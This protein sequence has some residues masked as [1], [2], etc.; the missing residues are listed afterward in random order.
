MS[1][2]NAEQIDSLLEAAGVDNTREILNAF[3][4]STEGLIAELQ[5]NVLDTDLE[6]ASLTAH[7]LKGAAANVGASMIVEGARMIETACRNGDDVSSDMLD[8]L[9]SEFMEA[10]QVFE[11]YLARFAATA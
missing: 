10:R 11:E 2:I 9:T 7:A 8:M 1:Q 6:N 3:W 4:Q 5:A